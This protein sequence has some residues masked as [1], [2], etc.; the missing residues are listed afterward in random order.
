M[1]YENDD[2]PIATLR[3]RCEAM[4]NGEGSL[5]LFHSALDWWRLHHYVTNRIGANYACTNAFKKDHKNFRYFLSEDGRDI[6]GYVPW[7]QYQ[8]NHYGYLAFNNLGVNDW[9]NPV[10]AVIC[11]RKFDFIYL[12][13]F[14]YPVHE[15]LLSIMFSRLSEKHI[16]STV[17]I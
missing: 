14:V 5:P 4:W 16:Q 9:A 6:F 13:L 17:Q 8:P 10:C 15:K 11:Q 2:E 3:D 7:Q 12:L 1:Y